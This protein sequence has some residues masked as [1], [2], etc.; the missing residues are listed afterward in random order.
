VPLFLGVRNRPGNSDGMSHAECPCTA[1]HYGVHSDQIKAL[2]QRTGAR[3]ASDLYEIYATMIRFFA[4]TSW[5][6]ANFAVA[7]RYLLTR[8]Q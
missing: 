3:I 6:G 2:M 4:C 8:L 7:H 1:R 5:Q